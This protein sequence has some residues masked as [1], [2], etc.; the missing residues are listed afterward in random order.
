MKI[1]F[2]LYIVCFQSLQWLRGWTT[3]EAIEAE[4]KD[5]VETLNVRLS[6]EDGS[7][8]VI[9]LRNYD[10]VSMCAVVEWDLPPLFL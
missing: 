2:L 6:V 10:D 5:L 3:P 7:Y 4:Y 1:Y 9:R 8:Y